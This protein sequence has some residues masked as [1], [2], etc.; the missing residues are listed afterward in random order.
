MDQAYDMDRRGK[1]YVQ[2]YDGETS[3]KM[4]AQKI[5]KEVGV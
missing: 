1:E 4:F 3:L 2:N 5:D